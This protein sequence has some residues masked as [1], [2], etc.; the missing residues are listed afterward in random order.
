MGGIGSGRRYSKHEHRTDVEVCPA[1]DLR[2]IKNHLGSEVFVTQKIFRNNR[3]SYKFL[4]DPS[5]ATDGHLTIHFSFQKKVQT[6]KITL[7]EMPCHLGGKRFFMLC[8]ECDGQFC[9]LYLRSGSWAC[10][11]CHG[12]AYLSQ[13]L[14]ARKR[15]LH[16]IQRIEK[17]KLKGTP[18]EQ[19]PYRMKSKTHQEIVEELAAHHIAHLKLAQKWHH[20]LK[21]KYF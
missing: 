16:A 17:K 11:H 20:D 5:E 3:E 7:T 8:P 12:L 10:K 4:I 1:V 19:K 9:L 14:N 13:R 21:D 6:Q 15:H 2:I 18:P